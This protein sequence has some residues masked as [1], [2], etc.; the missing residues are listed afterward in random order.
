MK[1]LMIATTFD[2]FES[3]KSVATAIIKAKVAACIQIS[4][5]VTSVYWWDGAVETADEH[6]MHIKTM[7]RYFDEVKK[8]IKNMHDY[9][10]PEIIALEISDIDEDY[11]KWMHETLKRSV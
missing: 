7:D 3:A 2:N 10:V 8:M 11:E 1:P 9:E 5:P 6:V 4:R